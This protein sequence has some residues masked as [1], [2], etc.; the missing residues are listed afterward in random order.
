MLQR[1]VE[2]RL[3]NDVSCESNG[4]GVEP[5]GNFDA[6]LFFAG[7]G[8]AEGEVL[9]EGFLASIMD[10]A[11]GSADLSVTKITNRL[12]KEIYEA[13]LT[14][15]ESKELKCSIRRRFFHAN[16]G[17]HWL[18]HDRLCF[19]LRFLRC[20]RQFRDSIA[21]DRGERPGAKGPEECDKGI[22][23]SRDKG[24]VRGRHRKYARAHSTGFGFIESAP[25]RKAAVIE[26]PEYLVY[27][28]FDKVRRRKSMNRILILA[29]ALSACGSN[30]EAPESVEQA[31][32]Q[33]AEALDEAT[34]PEAP[35]EAPEVEEAPSP[36]ESNFGTISIA[37]GFTPDPHV[38]SGTS[39][40]S[41]SA[42][43]L[44]ADCA[45][46]I[47]ATPDHL[48]VAGGVFTN[49]RVMAHS[50]TDVT[51]V[52]ERPDGTYLCNDDAEGDDPI[53]EST[54]AAGTYKIWVGSY[55]ADTNGRYTLGISEM[56]EPM[57]ST[58]SE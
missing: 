4:G 23:N 57:P 46:Q 55:N 48:L 52:V 43:D 25:Y 26:V 6:C 11:G 32:T 29:V 35:E 33:V 56:P 15:K 17:S 51:L 3:A 14:L 9:V 8:G 16:G 31:G 2:W 58:L 40:G 37:P 10:N 21:N 45:G 30:E 44:S 49:L 34:E 39:G 24:G 19:G 27:R 7:M 50:D 41:A 36:G 22:A 18:L 38:V 12:M 13:S 54:F 1:S 47:S 28:A 20:F 42:A 53:V 5:L